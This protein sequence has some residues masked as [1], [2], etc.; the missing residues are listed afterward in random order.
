MRQIYNS[1]QI[2]FLIDE[3]KSEKFSLLAFLDEEIIYLCSYRFFQGTWLFMGMRQTIEAKQCFKNAYV[4][5]FLY[6]ITNTHASIT[7]AKK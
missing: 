3:Y 4:C 7:Q 2:Y 6:S 1:Y 5:I